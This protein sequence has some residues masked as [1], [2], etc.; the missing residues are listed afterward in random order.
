MTLY[1]TYI[2]VG[3]LFF[4]IKVAFKKSYSRINA[5][6]ASY[7]IFIVPFVMAANGITLCLI[8]VDLLVKY[9]TVKFISFVY[10]TQC[11]GCYFLNL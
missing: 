8:N 10:N 7:F 2:L 3:T 4:Y 9:V 11:F 6:Y 1:C 5:L